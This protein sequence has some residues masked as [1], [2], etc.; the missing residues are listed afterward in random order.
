MLL[1]NE[2]LGNYKPT[3]LFLLKNVGFNKQHKIERRSILFGQFA[4]FAPCRGRTACP[5]R[6]P[7]RGLFP[8]VNFCVLK[9]QFLRAQ[10]MPKQRLNISSHNT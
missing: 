3:S 4:M 9:G 1:M 7:E 2:E 6:G 10:R 8:H 5:T